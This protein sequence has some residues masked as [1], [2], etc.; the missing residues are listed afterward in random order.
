MS[1]RLDPEL[2]DEIFR[3][4][5]EGRR[6][7]VEIHKILGISNPGYICQLLADHPLTKEERK[8]R[9]QKNAKFVREGLKNR[10]NYIGGDEWTKEQNRLL[11]TLWP[12]R[13][14]ESIERNFPDRSWPAITKHAAELGVRRSRIAGNRGVKADKLLRSLREI[15]EHRGI[16][17][18]DLADRIGLAPTHLTR[19]ELGE[20]RPSFLTLRAWI[21]ALDCDVMV[22]PKGNRV[23]YRVKKLW[24]E[25]DDSLLKELSYQGASAEEMSFVFKRQP[26]EIEKRCKELGLHESEVMRNASGMMRSRL[27]I[28]QKKR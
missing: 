18:N 10:G 21:D 14:R 1:K 8:I 13:S 22:I 16:S 12:S 24:G 6:S 19:C 4:R 3:L 2:K 15:R 5:I 26:A 23:A 27:K 20:C 17:R 11:K 7:S 28:P 9:R 25:R